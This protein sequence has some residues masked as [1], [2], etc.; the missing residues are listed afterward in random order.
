MPRVRGPLAPTWNCARRSWSVSKERRLGR[1]LEALLGRT[2]G[3]EESSLATPSQV[4]DGG[5]ATDASYGSYGTT[6]AGS[7]SEVTRSEDGQ[8]WLPLASID[9]NPYQPRT[10]FDESDIADLC[11]SIRTHGFL[12]PIVV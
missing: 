7:D 8:Q 6:G 12:Q 2:F 5:Y 3:N 4:G 11:D 10:T 1:G 9:R